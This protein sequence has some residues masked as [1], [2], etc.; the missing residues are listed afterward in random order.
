MAAFCAAEQR[1]DTS[2]NAV[3]TPLV[4][5][6]YYRSVHR[7]IMNAKKSILCAMYLARYSPKYPEGLEAKLLEEEAEERRGIEEELAEDLAGLREEWAVTNE[8][9]VSL[10]GETAA[11]A[12]ALT[13]KVDVLTAEVISS[14]SRADA[15][16][17]RLREFATTKDEI[18]GDLGE[19]NKTPAS[20]D[21]AAIDHNGSVAQVTGTGANEEAVFAY[22]RQ[23]RDSGRFSFVM[24]NSIQLHGVETAFSL[25]LS[26]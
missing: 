17:T 12:T 1:K 4:N 6:D 22:A 16:D 7:E 9:A 13:Q 15:L 5:A 10:S 23:L 2:Y 26:K 14:E 21:L 18:N 20:V 3:V 24:L 11:R 25:T 19:L 8:L